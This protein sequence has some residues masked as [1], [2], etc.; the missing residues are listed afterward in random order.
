MAAPE[1]HSLEQP[2][3]TLLPA[4]SALERERAKAM[5]KEL[6]NLGCV[7]FCCVGPEAEPLHDALDEII[8]TEGALEVVT[9]WIEDPTEAIEY[10][11][12]TAGGGRLNLLALIQAQSALLDLLQDEARRDGRFG[13]LD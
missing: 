8:E 7:E 13:A 9:T 3:V 6:L 1:D 10:F 5:A 11:L 12:H 4:Y 2:F